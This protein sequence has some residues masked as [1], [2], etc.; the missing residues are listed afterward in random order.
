MVAEKQSSIF[1]GLKCAIDVKELNSSSEAPAAPFSLQTY[2]LNIFKSLLFLETHA[3]LTGS[4]PHI[5]HFVL[6]IG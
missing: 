1:T 5:R 4:E 3:A 6:S 2:R